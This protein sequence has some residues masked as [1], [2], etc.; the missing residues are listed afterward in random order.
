M[1]TKAVSCQPNYEVSHLTY[2]CQSLCNPSEHA[3]KVVTATWPRQLKWPA[4]RTISDGPESKSA[5]KMNS[6]SMTAPKRSPLVRVAWMTS[7]RFLPS[8]NLSESVAVEGIK[9]RVMRDG[10]GSIAL[11]HNSFQPRQGAY[12]APETSAS[13]VPP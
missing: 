3:S 1:D 12:F 13:N 6:H 7:L 4:L 8:R 9:N 11:R 5:R 2:Y 10:F